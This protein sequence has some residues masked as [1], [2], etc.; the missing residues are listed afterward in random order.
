MCF[1]M[2]N[3][4]VLKGMNNGELNYD[5]KTKNGD[6]NTAMNCHHTHDNF[7]TTPKII[8]FRMKRAN[9]SFCSCF[10]TQ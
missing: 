2:D 4:G 8:L 1:V 6:Q 3:D 5:V 9:N 10:H 7:N